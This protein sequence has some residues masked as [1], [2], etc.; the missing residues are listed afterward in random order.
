MEMIM[1]SICGSRL[2]GQWGKVQEKYGAQL[3]RGKNPK[4][5]WWNDKIKAAIR[6]KEAA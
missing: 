2:N 1:S 4:S 6:R 3:V 5:V